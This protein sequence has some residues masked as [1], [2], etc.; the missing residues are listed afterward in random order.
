MS[1]LLLRALKCKNQERPPIWLMRQAGRYLPEYR[2]LRQRHSLWE[3]FHVPELAAEVTLLPI[4]LLEFDAAILFSDILV[5][6]EAL[7][8]KLDFPEGKGPQVSPLLKEPKDIYSLPSLPVSE[9]LDYVKKT[10]VNVKKELKIPLI[11]FCGGPFTVASYFIESS[12]RT[13]LPKTKEWLYKDPASFHHLLEIITSA[14]IDYLKMQIEAGVQAIQIF[15]SWINVLSE[16][17]LWE[18]SFKYLE[19]IFKAVQAQKVP[20]TV[21]CRGASLVAEQLCC[22]NP[23]A[24]SFDWQKPLSALRSQVPLHIAIQGN[25]DPH[26]LKAPRA[27]IRKEAQKLLSSMAADQGFIFNLGHGVLPDTP[28]EHVRELIDAVKSA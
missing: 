27:I 20:V 9:T 5:I 18:F 1:D 21:F 17:H 22:L 14:S 12:G 3:M 8:A 4:K 2:A 19:R 24:I 15:D 11:G 10:I 7:G 16:P 26:L 25:L 13:D 23:N 6:L 28:I